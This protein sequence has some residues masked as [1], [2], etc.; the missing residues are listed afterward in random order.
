[1]VWFLEYR[2]ENVPELLLCFNSTIPS[3]L[4]ALS[5]IA[6]HLYGVDRAFLHN[7]LLDPEQLGVPRP[8]IYSTHRYGL[9]RV[10]TLPKFR[11]ARKEIGPL[12]Y[13]DQLPGNSS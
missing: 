10:Q 5:A 6:P 1:M 3:L 11:P 8:L 9:I 13:N 7:K 12:Y 2:P 4:S